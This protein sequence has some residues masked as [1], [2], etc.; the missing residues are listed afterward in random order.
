MPSRII[1]L[2][3]VFE[4]LTARARPYK[5]GKLLSETLTILGR[6]V[7]NHEIDPDLFDVFI[8]QGV[9]LD[10]ARQYLEPEQIDEVD[11]SRI[12]GYVP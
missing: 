8:R 7:Q 6:M 11:L 10:Y 2:A 1:C 5:P 12:P 4:A 3:D 9:W